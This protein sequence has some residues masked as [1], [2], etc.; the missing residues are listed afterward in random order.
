MMPSAFPVSAIISRLTRSS[1]TAA[2]LI[3]TFTRAVDAAA[4]AHSAAAATSLRTLGLPITTSASAEI[5]HHPGQADDL[6]RGPG[7][8]GQSLGDGPGPVGLFLVGGLGQPVGVGYRQERIRIRVGQPQRDVPQFVYLADDPAHGDLM[9][10]VLLAGGVPGHHA[11][12]RRALGGEQRR[13]GAAAGGG[14]AL[15]ELVEE[16]ADLLVADGHVS[17]G[18]RWGAVPPAKILPRKL[19]RPG[20]PGPG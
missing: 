19:V 20:H 7:G 5:D 9:L 2:R 10:G 1:E 15:G 6:G 3:S 18:S 8:V 13:G 16:I 17:S 4:R 11:E 12:Q 14:D